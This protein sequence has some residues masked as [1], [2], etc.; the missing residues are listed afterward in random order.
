[1]AQVMA[2][3]LQGISPHIFKNCGSLVNVHL[4]NG[5]KSIGSRSFEKCIKLEDLYIPDTVEHIGDGLCCGC[6]YA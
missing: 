3:H 6:S 1:M 4:S 2:F 5:L